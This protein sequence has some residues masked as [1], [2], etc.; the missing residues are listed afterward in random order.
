MA[1]KRNRRIDAKEVKRRV[2]KATVKVAV[3]LMLYIAA[4]QFLGPVFES[5]PGFAGSIEA[6][7]IAYMV[8]IVVGYLTARTILQPIVNG[9]RAL[10]LVFYMVLALGDSLI[11]VT[12]GNTTLTVDLSMVFSAGIILSLVGFA[13]AVLEAIG[14]LNERAEQ[15]SG[16]S[17]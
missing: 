11:S 3:I 15:K 1:E 2:V 16:L 6:F 14:F 4:M 7:V 10:L 17:P 8:L 5:V 13:G 12:S 9:A